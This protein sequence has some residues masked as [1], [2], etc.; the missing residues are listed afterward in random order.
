MRRAL[1]PSAVGAAVFSQQV[2]DV[3]FLHLR[4]LVAACVFAILLSSWETII[5]H[6]STSPKHLAFMSVL[7]DVDGTPGPVL[8]S[9]CPHIESLSLADGI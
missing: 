6:P 5:Q 2:C 7:S 3:R 4:A 1:K 8:V 9:S